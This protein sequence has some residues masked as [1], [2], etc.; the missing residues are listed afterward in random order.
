M[1]AKWILMVALAAFAQLSNA[2]EKSVTVFVR[3]GVTESFL[4]SADNDKLLTGFKLG[5]GTQISLLKSGRLV[6][7]PTVEL[8]QKGG[9][10]TS[11]YGGTVTM[12]GLYVHV[13]LDVA[14]QFRARKGR[15]ITIA[16][17]PYIGYGIGGKIYGSDGMYFYRHIPVDR[18]YDMF[19]KE[20]DLQR[21]DAGLHTMF[22]YEFNRVLVGASFEMGFKSIFKEEWSAYNNATTPCALSLH[23]GYRF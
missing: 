2:R 19:G 7:L 20:A 18:H 21:W 16:M 13:P 14:L 23:I 3:G 1:K 15:Y 12:R 10:I 6:L 5:M 8:A 11:E 4:L 22:Q 17:G 9:I